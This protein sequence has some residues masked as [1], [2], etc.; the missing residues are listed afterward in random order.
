MIPPFAAARLFAAFVLLLVAAPASAQGT[1]EDY[2]RAAEI[3]ERYRNLVVDVVEDARWDEVPGAFILRRTVEGGRE[4]ILLDPTTAAQAPAFDHGALAGALAAVTGEDVEPH[5][6]PFSTFRYVG[7]LA[8]IELT[9]D[10]TQLRCTLAPASCERA[11]GENR[12]VGGQGA[13]VGAGRA[14]PDRTL[15]ARVE[16]YNLVVHQGD[17]ILYRTR[18][19]TE[20]NRYLAGSIEWSPDS[21]RLVAHR[22]VPGYRRE[23]HFVET[24]PAD[25]LQPRLHT[26]EYTKPGDVLEVRRPVII[27]PHDGVQLEVDPALFPNAYSVSAPRWREDGR[28]FTFEYNQ[29]GHDLY[30]VIGV[31]GR[32]G[33]A[34]VIIDEDPETFFYYRP[35]SQSGKRFRHDVDDGREIIWMSERD[36]WN[37]LYLYDDRGHSVRAITRGDWV[38]RDVEHVDEDRREIVFGA[39]GMDPE[40]DPYFVHFY[41]IGFDGSGLTRLTDGDG[42]HTVLFSPDREHYLATWS[43][44]DHPPVT[45]LRRSSDG[46]VLAEVARGDHSA[47]LEAGWHPPEVFWAVGR[48]GE[49][50]IRGIIVRPS[51]FDPDRS[52]PVVESIYAG[53]HDHHVPTTFTV[54]P[55]RGMLE[56]AEL[57]FITVMIDGMGTSSRSK[58]FHDV[59]WKNLGDAGFAD[60]ILWHEAVAGTYDWYDLERVGIYGGSA[61]GQ[62]AMGGL[63]F[64]PEFYHVGVAHNGCHD[65]RMDKIWWNEL[66]MGWPVGP[67]YDASSN[68]V[69]AH[70]LEGR[71]LLTVGEM[72]TNVD[73]ASTYQVADALIRAGKEF[74][75]FVVPGGG[76]ARGPEHVRKR[77]DF[78]VRHLMDVPPPDWNRVSLEASVR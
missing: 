11:T 38:V 4:F 69:H 24:A 44:V 5:A 77:W 47:L 41:R 7:D 16:G 46:A 21:R 67:E 75:F 71:L 48:D 63:L 61:G 20:G 23:M 18:D 57:G 43:R 62:N 60:R 52:Y 66:W 73:P 58:A 45:E 8:T 31:D 49:T 26:R 55:P 36:G 19:G 74:D 65:N 40:E 64:H 56:V 10:G 3:E 37:H 50:P 13:G 54:I 70:R 39:S 25:Q 29:R 14:S 17:S 59:A 15:E 78:L 9:A 72:D 2:R 1:L 35:S 30:R 34:R 27:V 22:A 6:L 68:V 12:G 51:T 53:P 32:T 28:E 76:H 33:E 42:D